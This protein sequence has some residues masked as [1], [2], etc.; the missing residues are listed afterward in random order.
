MEL[1]TVPDR[2]GPKNINIKRQNIPQVRKKSIF[3]VK[4]ENVHL[5]LVIFRAITMYSIWNGPQ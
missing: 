2:Q 3:I 1:T 4:V 5:Q